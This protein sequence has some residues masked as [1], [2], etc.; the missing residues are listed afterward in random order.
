MTGPGPGAADNRGEPA[1]DDT[2]WVA[3]AI[4]PDAV[5]RLVSDGVPEAIARV[6]AARGFDGAAARDFLSPSLDRAPDPFAMKGMEAAVD[7][8]V[9]TARRGERIVIFGDYDVDGVTAVAQLRAVFRA[10]G[11]DAV[12]FLPHRVRDG[13]GLK[14]ETFRK[15][16]AEHRPRAIVTVDCGITAVEAVAEAA[17]A[18]VAV[19]ITDHH[20]PPDVLPAGAAV[21]NPK[22]PGCGY[23]FKDLCGAGIA[24]KIAQAI[25]RR[26]RLTLSERSL[27]KVAA[28][29][30]I[31]DIVPLVG[32]NRAIVA[33]GLAALSDPRAPGLKALLAEAGIAGRAPTSEEVAF[34]VGPRLNA[35]GRLDTADLALSVFEERDSG[36]AA[37][38]ARELSERNTERQGHERRVVAEAR[39]RVLESGEAPDGIVIEAEAGWPRGVLGIAASRLAR[40]FR[41]PVF[42]FALDGERAVGSGR[43]IPGLSLHEAL[44]EIREHFVEFGGHAQACGGAVEAGR[45]AGFRERARALFRERL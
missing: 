31:A 5:G 19:V 37:G 25:I 22:Q 33:E 9:S 3:A 32:E 1:P 23:P 6:L 7:A 28:L 2:R 8:L 38:I 30:T 4:D 36:R 44:S 45:F 18:G 39:R 26:E 13:Y 14:P 21:V 12:P 15:V 34:R 41:C 43:S 20:L 42:L 16:F 40:E 24:F 29:G 10:L 27:A 35:A 17:R 11:A